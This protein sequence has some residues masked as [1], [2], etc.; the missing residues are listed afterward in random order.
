[1][2]DTESNAPMPNRKRRLLDMMALLKS[3]ETV[4]AAE[5][6]TKLKAS[7]RTIYRDIQTLR[8]SG[9]PVRGEAGVGYCLTA[10]VLLPPLNLTMAE[11]EALHLGIAVMTEAEDPSLRDAA[12]TLA[13]KIDVSLPEGRL[14]N[15][16]GWGL[17]VHPFA[18]TAAGIRHMPAIRKAIRKRQKL[19]ITASPWDSE[20]FRGVIQPLKLDYWG[21]VW[22]CH[23]WDTR[24]KKFLDLRLDE[25]DTLENA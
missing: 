21:R 11:T 19:S 25:I 5:M 3:G 1:M 13:E 6:S 23:S 16:F 2:P 4:T 14:P 9:F 22:T 17:A 24:A 8:Q 15:T 12:R 18:D 20:T 10:E 7:E